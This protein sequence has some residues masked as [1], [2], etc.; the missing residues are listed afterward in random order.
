MRVILAGRPF[1]EGEVG[2]Q[3]GSRI[4][5]SECITSFSIDPLLLMLHEVNYIY[6]LLYQH[7]TLKHSSCSV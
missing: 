4:I 2:I 1:F 6:M 5:A 3:C 7:P